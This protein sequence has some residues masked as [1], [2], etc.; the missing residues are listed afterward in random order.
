M[1][2]RQAPQGEESHSPSSPR[3]DPKQLPMLARLMTPVSADKVVTSGATTVYLSE[4]VPIRRSSV[5]SANQ[6][7]PPKS[8]KPARSNVVTTTVGPPL[9]NGPR[10][11]LVAIGRSRSSSGSSN[12]PGTPSSGLP[13]S[14]TPQG[15]IAMATVATTS[16]PQPEQVN[17]HKSE[18]FYPCKTIKYMLFRCNSVKHI[19]SI[20]IQHF[21]L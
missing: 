15:A 14:S 4:S 3:F 11:Q 20:F 2:I 10:P 9:T 13:Q 7:L 18:K 19:A 8:P 6:Q 1:S 17:L 21:L 12:R 16:L 5:S